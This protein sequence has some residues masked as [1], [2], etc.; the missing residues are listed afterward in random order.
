[1]HIIFIYYRNLQN[2]IMIFPAKIYYIT[3]YTAI[4]MFYS[5]IKTVSMMITRV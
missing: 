2:V 1:M 5:F 4:R 3:I